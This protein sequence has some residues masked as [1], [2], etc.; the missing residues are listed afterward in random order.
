MRLVPLI[1][2]VRAA[3]R[4]VVA[5]II[6][7]ALSKTLLTILVVVVLL[8]T[9]CEDSEAIREG[10]KVGADGGSSDRARIV[11]VWLPF[12]TLHAVVLGEEEATWLLD[13]LRDAKMTLIVPQATLALLEVDGTSL[14]DLL[15]VEA[16]TVIDEELGIS[17]LDGLLHPRD[18]RQFILAE[19]DPVLL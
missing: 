12:A 10:A 13:V 2:I 4:A 1:V 18:G 11:R 14:S 3:A 7:D 8:L 17:A 19:V 9:I 6:D 16:E 15:D 5:I